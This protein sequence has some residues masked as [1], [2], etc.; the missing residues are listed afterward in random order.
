MIF[1]FNIMLILL[2]IIVSIFIIIII[3]RDGL[4][5]IGTAHF[6]SLL[7]QIMALKHSIKL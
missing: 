3:Y 4:E 2:V 5:L 7:I 1:Y 6:M